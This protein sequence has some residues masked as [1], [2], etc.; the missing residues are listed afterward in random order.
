[1]AETQPDSDATGGD[2]N[3]YLEDMPWPPSSFGMGQPG[4]EQASAMDPG[5][6]TAVG[7][8]IVLNPPPPPPKKDEPKKLAQETPEQGL[9]PVANA[10]PPP[11]V[12]ITAPTTEGGVP[13]DMSPPMPA[14]VQP[15][16]EIPPPP[17]EAPTPT[18]RDVLG[19][20]GATIEQE[21]LPPN[22]QSD[23]ETAN[24]LSQDAERGGHDLATYTAD[25]ERR[26][27]DFVNAQLD[28]TIAASKQEAAT[29]IAALTAAMQ[30]GQQQR[31]ALD[32]QAKQLAAT[33]IDTN[34]HPGVLGGILGL[35]GVAIG[36]AASP[37]TGGRNLALEELDRANNEHIEAQKA[38][39]ANKWRA[40]GYSNDQIDRELNM[41]GTTYQALEAE[42][43]S[44]L[45]F[46]KQQIQTAAQN[47]DPRST[48]VAQLAQLYTQVDGLYQQ[49][50]AN[51]QQQATKD[52][53]DRL[54]LQEEQ[55][56]VGKMTGMIGGGAPAVN[57]ADVYSPDK[58]PSTM[59]VPPKAWFDS[60]GGKPPTIKQYQQYLDTTY[61]GG[62][63]SKEAEDAVTS[64]PDLQLGVTAPTESGSTEYLMN[65]KPDGTK[66]VW[67]AR[68]KEEAAKTSGLLAAT[69]SYHRLT[70]DIIRDIQ[71][72]GWMSD[73]WKSPA[74]Q[75]QQSRLESA[76]AEL[77]DAYDIKR[78]G[79]NTVEFFKKIATAGMDPTGVRDASGALRSS[80]QDL[81]NKVNDKLRTDHYNGPRVHFA[82]TSKL[83]AVS[84]P[85]EQSFK[86]MLGWQTN[87]YA[88]GKTPEVAK[89]YGS[90]NPQAD[91][92][93]YSDDQANEIQRLAKAAKGGDAGSMEQLRLFATRAD[94]PGL[95]QYAA[96]TLHD[97]TGQQSTDGTDYSD[98]DTKFQ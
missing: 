92:R 74:W 80:A 58:F 1:M 39:L 15:G 66:Y 26:R 4:I 27:Q 82:D 25:L 67:H 75:T 46:A 86:D 70:D 37:F 68:S 33:K 8:D 96:A 16:P 31:D 49:G 40:L 59:P 41:A 63:A 19:Q 76:I 52:A 22:E 2:P 50:L 55:I 11:M 65:T 38:D 56:K 48:R 81:E 83:G 85:E 78:F 89:S 54:K 30:H 18:V 87:Q 17:A 51:A 71:T 61:K 79:D 24:K 90:D 60:F 93:G 3:L 21:P 64:D 32:A 53:M 94:S 72:H 12:P 84:S 29:H 42:R 43:L 77:H 88:Y 35:I 6:L 20:Q 14:P 62:E 44:N 10:M 69:R 23:V 34:L 98:V 73:Y 91:I 45:Q 36:G 9:P 7:R 97:V 57:P 28:Q 13:V 95:R 5:M 47:F